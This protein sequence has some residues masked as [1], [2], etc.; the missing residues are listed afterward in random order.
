MSRAKPAWQCA[1][2]LRDPGARMRCKR[3]RAVGLDADFDLV[4]RKLTWRVLQAGACGARFGHRAVPD[5]PDDQV[6]DDDTL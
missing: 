5:P 2:P 4:Q 6:P 1:C 3:S